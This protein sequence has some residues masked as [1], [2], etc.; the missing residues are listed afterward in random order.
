MSHFSSA[1][2]KL[3]GHRLENSRPHCPLD[4][5]FKAQRV[6]CEALSEPTRK[7]IGPLVKPLG[8][9]A[10]FKDEAP[11]LDEWVRF[12]KAQGFARFYLFDDCSSDNFAE[13]LEPY[14]R[15][16]TVSLFSAPNRTNH[17]RRQVNS[18]SAALNRAK[19]ECDWLAFIDVD[20]FFFS[21]QGAIR[22]VLP[23]DFLVSGVFVWWRLFGS[24]GHEEAPSGG[25]VESYVMTAPFPTT[26]IDTRKVLVHNGLDFFDDPSRPPEAGTLHGKSIV[27]PKRIL[28]TGVHVPSRYFGKIVDENGRRVF[29]SSLV[30][31]VFPRLA[32]KTRA[33]FWVPTQNKLRIN[34]YWSK[35]IT[36]LQAKA[37]RSEAFRGQRRFEDYLARDEGFNQVE[38][39]TILRKRTSRLG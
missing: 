3:D 4:N 19:N 17:Y 15:E 29:W 37:L 14:I 22:D 9:A 13:V 34:H 6:I 12:H 32:Q 30:A 31:R 36:E 1:V 5:C 10:M 11:Y 27:R 28:Q 26:L 7:W 21:P 25:V 8:I 39:R 2:G 23:K 20:E 16:G 24:S 35:S 33:W 38:D 18:Y